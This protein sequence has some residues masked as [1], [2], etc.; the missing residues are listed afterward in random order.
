MSCHTI[1]PLPYAILVLFTLHWLAFPVAAI[2]R[3]WVAKGPATAAWS[4]PNNWSPIGTP[5]DGDELRFDF[6]SFPIPSATTM[7]NDLSGLS[8]QQLTFPS[9]SWQLS[10]NDLG[11]RS[12]IGNSGDGFVEINCAIRLEGVGSSTFSALSTLP[13]DTSDL[14]LTG[15]IDLNGHTLALVAR[16]G[17]TLELAGSISG[18]GSIR[19]NAETLN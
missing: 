10:G 18:A 19:I 8:V 11:V 14:R 13:S 17:A 6:E 9:G 16:S 7:V 1:R 15:P 12:T 2:Q 3:D 5:Q 4:N